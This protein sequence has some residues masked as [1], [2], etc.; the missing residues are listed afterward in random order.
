MRLPAC[1][2]L[3][4]AGHLPHRGGDPNLPTTIGTTLTLMHESGHSGPYQLVQAHGPDYAVVVENRGKPVSRGDVDNA[5]LFERADTHGLGPVFGVPQ[6]QLAEL[7]VPPGEERALAVDRE[8][9]TRP[10]RH[11]HDLPR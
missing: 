4:R 7:V 11:F 6:S 5:R 10:A 9:V 3:R 2:R 8:H 1:E